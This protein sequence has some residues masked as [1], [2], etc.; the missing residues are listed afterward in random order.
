MKI[1]SNIRNDLFPPGDTNNL[2][3]MMASDDINVLTLFKDQETISRD[4][5]FMA[6]R[7]YRMTNNEVLEMF[8]FANIKKDGILSIEE[9]KAFTQIFVLPFHICDYNSDHGLD[10][11]ELKVCIFKHD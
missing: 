4:E 9:W 7:F 11:H 10:Q 8:G 5:F 6:F 3:G 1:D 2:Y